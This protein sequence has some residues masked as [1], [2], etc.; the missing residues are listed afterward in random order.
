MT[1]R[2]RRK[3]RKSMSQERFDY[4]RKALVQEIRDGVRAEDISDEERDAFNVAR[5][6]A[7]FQNCGTGQ[8]QKSLEPRTSFFEYWV[9]G[10][11]PNTE[12][13]QRFKIRRLFAEIILAAID[14]VVGALMAIKLMHII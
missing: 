10:K 6:Q 3:I 13:E 1:N 9:M 2:R 7:N 5:M 14:G 8:N 12:D 11:K 4:V